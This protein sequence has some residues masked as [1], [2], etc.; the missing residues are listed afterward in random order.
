MI[1]SLP[2]L[3]VYWGLLALFTYNY[4]VFTCLML[5]SAF[6]TMA[7]VLLAI[8]SQRSTSTHRINIHLI[9]YHFSTYVDWWQDKV[10]KN[11]DINIDYLSLN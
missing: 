10:C 11:K 3:D 2:L 9:D 1:A 5:S 6:I 8:K 4:N 7:Q